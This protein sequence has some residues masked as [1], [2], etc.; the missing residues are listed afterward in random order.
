M[1]V[2]N[3]LFVLMPVEFNFSP[4]LID[5]RSQ[6]FFLIVAILITTVAFSAA[7][8]FGLGSRDTARQI[9]AG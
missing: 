9:A 6:C 3:I 4:E 1:P 7:L 5:L 2:K 8:A